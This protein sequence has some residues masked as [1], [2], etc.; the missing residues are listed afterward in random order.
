MSESVTL[1]DEPAVV[2]GVTTLS[3][4]ADQ[5]QIEQLH[6]LLAQSDDGTGAAF[7][8]VDIMTD[9]DPQRIRVA[10]VGPEMRSAG[11]TGNQQLLA[12]RDSS[13]MD[14]GT[15]RATNQEADSA[16]SRRVR[17]TPPLPE[18]VAAK[19]EQQ[20]KTATGVS[21]ASPADNTL[22]ERKAPAGASETPKSAAALQTRAQQVP[23]RKM[24]QLDI[25]QQT[26]GAPA[27]VTATTAQPTTP[28]QVEKL[29]KL[30]ERERA[31]PSRAR[32]GQPDDKEPSRR[33]IEVL[34][35]LRN[36]RP[37]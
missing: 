12:A 10:G 24:K 33:R 27:A 17:G 23:V 19:N 20:A 13:K 18:S 2:K 4:E 6:G 5:K 1:Q 14:E 31:E 25:R 8:L 21:G 28:D 37:E 26:A 36:D 7:P 22:A 3:I 16:T 15:E 35:I 32:V 30:A 11:L 34:L 29:K 9:T